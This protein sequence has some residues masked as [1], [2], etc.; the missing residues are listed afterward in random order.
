MTTLREDEDFI[1]KIIPISFLESA[2]V[3]IGKNMEPEDVFSEKSLDMW[4]DNNGYIKETEDA[5]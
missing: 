4:A 1:A 3:W 2:M 5:D